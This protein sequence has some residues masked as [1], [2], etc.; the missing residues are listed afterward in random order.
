MLG[1]V[2]FGPRITGEAEGARIPGDN[3]AVGV[4]TALTFADARRL[5]SLPAILSA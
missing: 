3:L 1:L 4:E 5:I 2:I